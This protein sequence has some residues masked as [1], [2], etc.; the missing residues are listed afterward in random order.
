MK[1]KDVEELKSIA[2]VDAVVIGKR[3]SRY[4]G[5]TAIPYT[6]DEVNEQYAPFNVNL[7]KTA[8]DAVAERIRLKSVELEDE[9]LT[10]R[11]RRLFQRANFDAV[12]P[13]LVT[14]MLALGKSY[15]LV[16]PDNR[17]V[18]SVTA[19]SPLAMTVDTHPVSG[20]VTRALKTWSVDRGSGL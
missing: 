15:A 4:Q 9:Q 7:C 12:L 18:I 16:W 6:M 5:K 14:E 1:I 8:V 10:A 17:G 20:E 3:H 11:A 2:H 13:A 19:E